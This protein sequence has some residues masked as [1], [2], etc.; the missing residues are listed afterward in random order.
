MLHAI[1][2]TIKQIIDGRSSQWPKVRRAWL[3]D[4]PTC[5]GCGTRKALEVHHIIP[6]SFCKAFELLVTNFLTL[7]E[8]HDCHLI[9]GH[10]GNYEDVNPWSVED[11][12]KQLAR[13]Q[14][15]CKRSDWSNIGEREI[16]D[17]IREMQAT[18][19]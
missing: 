3:V 6:F 2:R 11:A 16:A 4:H 14:K 15:R 12:A 19:A 8:Y 13:I 18:A 1:K 5:A 7:C 10:G 17:I 9:L